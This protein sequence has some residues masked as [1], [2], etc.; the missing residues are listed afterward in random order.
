MNGVA[1]HKDARH[2]RHVLERLG[3]LWRRSAGTLSGVDGSVIRAAL[4]RRLQGLKRFDDFLA[5]DLALSVD[6]F[7]PGALRRPLEA[8]P[9]SVVVAG[10]ECHVDYEIDAGVGI[11][12]VRLKER[13]AR[14]VGPQD[15]PRLDR[16][17]AFTVVRG[18]DATVR[19]RSLEELRRL[20]SSG[21]RPGPGSRARARKHRRRL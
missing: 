1:R 6:E 18:K 8:L 21:E 2:L 11:A 5:A 20:L 17:V 19:A 16:P 15:L 4:G 3:E 13:L 7:V 10:E 14:S 9:A 12:R